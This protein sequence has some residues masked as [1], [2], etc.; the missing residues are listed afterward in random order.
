[1]SLRRADSASSR[2]VLGHPGG[3]GSALAAEGPLDATNV[4]V[5][6]GGHREAVP[7][8]G[9]H[10]AGGTVAGTATGDE[11]LI[12]TLPEGVEG[13]LKETSLLSYVSLSHADG[14]LVDLVEVG[15]DA[16][17][18]G[19]AVA[20]GDVVVVAVAGTG[21]DGM[22]LAEWTGVLA[23]VSHSEGLAGTHAVRCMQTTEAST[24]TAPICLENSSVGRHSLLRR[25]HKLATTALCLALLCSPICSATGYPI[26]GSMGSMTSFSPSASSASALLPRWLIIVGEDGWIQLAAREPT[27]QQPTQMTRHHLSLP[28]SV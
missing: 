24:S 5:G 26:V 22:R 9:R 15:A 13:G 8:V 27:R 25:L 28:R 11:E 6:G 23:A 10:G 2:A 4:G 20:G 12:Q 14:L 17:V 3:V 1:M 19:D 16:G 18:S 7:G 21:G